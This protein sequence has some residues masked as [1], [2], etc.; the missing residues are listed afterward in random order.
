MSASEPPP[1]PPDAPGAAAARRAKRRIVVTVAVLVVIGA[2]VAKCVSHQLWIMNESSRFEFCDSQM[3]DLASA[4][5]AQRMRDPKRAERWSGSALWIA[6]RQDGVRAR[7]G[8]DL[9]LV[10]RGDLDAEAADDLTGVDLE[11]PPRE[12][13]SYAGRDFANFPLAAD[14]GEPQPIGACVHHRG[15]AVVGFDDGSVR[16]MD[17]AELGLAAGDDIVCGPESKSPLLRQLLG[18]N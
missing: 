15:G 11:H 4:F 18:G 6:M 16:K 13:C 3:S 2:G 12:L 5:A 7:D 8:R 9:V 10:C 1:I 17:R 14:A